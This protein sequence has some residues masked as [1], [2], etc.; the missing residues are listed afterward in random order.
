MNGCGND[1]RRRAADET[2]RPRGTAKRPDKG[3]PNL[4]SGANPLPCADEP[5]SERMTPRASLSPRASHSHPDALPCRQQRLARPS[6]LAF[7]QPCRRDYGTSFVSPQPVPNLPRQVVAWF[8]CSCMSTVSKRRQGQPGEA[9]AGAARRSADRRPR[10][11]RSRA[12]GS[13]TERA[14]VVTSAQALVSEIRRLCSP[15]YGNLSTLRHQFTRRTLRGETR[16]TPR[17][18]T[19]R[20]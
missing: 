18:C 19:T 4:N 14:R 7:P 16:H 11:R 6:A 12:L 15:Q 8:R 3:V 20:L 2:S 17:R 5:R 9:S 1:A 10:P 13:L